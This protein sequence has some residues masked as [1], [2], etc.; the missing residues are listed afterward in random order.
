MYY[1]YISNW[2]SFG[3]KPIHK[4][5]NDDDNDVKRKNTELLGR[6]IGGNFRYEV[7]QIL[8]AQMDQLSMFSPKKF[9]SPHSHFGQSC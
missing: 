3:I 5:D 4:Y 6:K 1:S 8:G 7:I 2:G 9:D